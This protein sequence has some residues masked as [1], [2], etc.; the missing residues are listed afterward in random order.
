M[1][2][3]ILNAFAHAS[4]G[5]G[6]SFDPV[7]FFLLAS[8]EVKLVMI[9]LVV[10]FLG[11]LVIFVERLIAFLRS[12]SHSVK[13][14]IATARAF[15]DYDLDGA[16]HTASK[17][18]FKAGH[19]TALLRAG[20]TEIKENPNSMGVD[21]AERAIE[22]QTSE[23]LAKLKQWFGILATVASTAPFVGL[24]GTTRGV[25]SAFTAMGTDGAG[26]S[27][28]SIGISEAL[29]TTFFGIVVA[30]L[31]V[32]FFNFFNGRL[33]KVSE[34]LATA[35]LDILTWANKFVSRA[36]G[37]DSGASAPE[38]QVDLA[39]APGK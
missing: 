33:E 19:L 11:S 8:W 21:A 1:T 23:Q 22:K 25:I 4:E 34:E 5:E 24:A 9:V 18:D 29:W 26:L 7:T 17:P 6:V 30:I 32:W 39:P 37:A 13:V 3:L 15:K 2:W 12:R 38:A 14:A 20:L 27:S 16:L 36:G 31:G 28:I 10:M 35:K